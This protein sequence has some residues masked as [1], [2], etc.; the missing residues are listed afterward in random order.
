MTVSFIGH[1]DTPQNIKGVLRNLLIDLI[2]RHNA[3]TFYVGNQGSFDNIVISVLRELKS[4]Y[5][6]IDYAVVIAYMPRENEKSLTDL[7]T[8][9]P[10][11]LETVPPKYA[12]AS[13]NRWI[14]ENSDILVSYV[15]H[16]VGGAAKFK[17]LA[18]KKHKTVINI[19]NENKTADYLER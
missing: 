17:E 2:E 1:R 15:T 13:R 7:P 4:L 11:G 18:E 9:Y 8:L 19:A 10:H 14:I 6:N 3:T 12:I 5:P 16:N